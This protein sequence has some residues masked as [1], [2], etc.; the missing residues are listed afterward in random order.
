MAKENG[1]SVGE[2]IGIE[3]GKGETG[4]TKNKTGTGKGEK[5]E[6]NKSTST[7]NK[8]TRTSST[9]SKGNNRSE[10][11]EI[12]ILE[13]EKKKKKGMTKADQEL[14]DNV[15]MLLETGFS[16]VSM[17]AGD[18][19]VISA[20]E[21]KMI[22]EPATKIL[23][24]FDVNKKANKYMDL[25]ALVTALSI[26]AI[27]RVI[28]STQ[29]KKSEVKSIERKTRTNN[30]EPINKDSKDFTSNKSLSAQIIES[31]E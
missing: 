28:V 5:Q 24:R 29:N 18:H 21:S 3:I 27:P 6:S 14:C 12:P 2:P 26:V 9:T 13:K 10:N 30:V 1:N 19:W 31:G 22:A 8:K 25:L 7:R 17:K 23:K 20:E 11:I 16:V 4:T 15:A